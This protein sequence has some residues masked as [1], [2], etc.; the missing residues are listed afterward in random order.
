[1]RPPV[2]TTAVWEEALAVMTLHEEAVAAELEKLAAARKRMPMV[3]VES[4]YRFQ[5][6]GGGV[7]LVDLFEG[8]SQLILYRFFF[9]EGVDGWPDAGC[10]GCSSWA[11]GVADLNLLH[12]RDIT[13]A[14]ASPAPQPSLKA[15]AERM[16]W[17]D[18][19]WY[20]IKSGSFTEDFGATEWF[21][22]NVFLRDGDTVHRTYFL[23]N[24]TMVSNIGSVSS[25]ASLT[26]Y[27]G[28]VEGEDVPD[29]WPQESMSYWMRRH[30]EFNE[31]APS[32]RS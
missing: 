17:T 30:D 19:P 15:Y 3:R 10:V 29:G 9:E 22:L 16:G 32:A 20:T 18:L 13:F 12:A 21:A 31:P 23:Q 2:V 27:G 4:D 25:L 28:Q 8:R 5:G 14:M 7:S 24:G 1:M 26:V 11:D 6:P